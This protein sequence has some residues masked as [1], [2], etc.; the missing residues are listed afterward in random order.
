MAAKNI[1]HDDSMWRFSIYE[2]RKWVRI[3]NILQNT[4]WSRDT[5]DRK[6]NDGTL[7]KKKIGGKVYV[8]WDSWLAWTKGS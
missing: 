7:V 5:I 2:G 3:A 8:L 6:L 4:D 1:K